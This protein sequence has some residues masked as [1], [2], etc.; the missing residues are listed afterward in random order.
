MTVSLVEEY[1]KPDEMVILCVIPAMSDFGNA[2]ARGICPNMSLY[3]IGHAA[4]DAQ[5]RGVTCLCQVVKLARK[6][7]PQGIRT[8][9]VVTKCDDAARA[10]SSDVVEKV[11][12][13]CVTH[14]SVTTSRSCRLC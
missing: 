3:C 11:G 9:G 5:N 2:E 4:L 12:K 8:L 6:Y 1:I 10:E 13:I 7:D 14:E